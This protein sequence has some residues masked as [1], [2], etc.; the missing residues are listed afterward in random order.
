MLPAVATTALVDDSI[1]ARGDL[2]PRSFPS[3][4]M[5]RGRQPDHS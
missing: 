4:A 3:R 2:Q 1:L 5:G